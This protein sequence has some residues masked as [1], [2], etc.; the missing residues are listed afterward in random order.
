L[1]DPRLASEA[2]IGRLILLPWKGGV[3]KEVKKKKF[4]SF[5]YLAMWQGMR[6]ENLNID[7]DQ[8]MLVTCLQTKVAVTFTSDLM[9]LAEP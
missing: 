8:D 1:E 9:K 2:M 5:R 3:E 6:G 7:T 4:G